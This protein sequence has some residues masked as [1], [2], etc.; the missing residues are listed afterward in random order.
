MESRIGLTRGGRPHPQSIA[1][2]PCS[3][4][5][6]GAGARPHSL[7][8]LHGTRSSD[9]PQRQQQQHQQSR[10]PHLCVITGNSFT[11]STSTASTSSSISQTRNTTTTIH[12]RGGRLFLPLHVPGPACLPACLLGSLILRTLCPL[13]L[14]FGTPKNI[15]LLLLGP[16]SQSVR[17]TNVP[18][19]PFALISAYN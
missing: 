6:A 10:V 5:G 9:T 3:G 19:S 4:A 1:S 14:H 15:L 2:Y 17:F 18:F 11:T 8:G 12:P 13:P 7:V 16:N